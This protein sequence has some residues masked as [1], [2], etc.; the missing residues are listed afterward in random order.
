MKIDQD[1]MAVLANS[2]VRGANLKLPGQLDRKLYERV[3]KVLVAIGGKWDRKAQAHV[4][5]EDADAMVDGILLTGEYTDA[6]KEF[7][8]FYTPD[9]IAEMV[10]ERANIWRADDP[11]ERCRVLEPSAGAGALV[12]AAR[13][14]GA[15]VWACE[16]NPKDAD[17][18]DLLLYPHGSC[19]RGDFLA[20]SPDMDGQAGP[21]FDRVV[22]NPPFSKGQDARHV[23]HALK[24][25]KPGGRLVAIMSP[26]VV[27]RTNGAY[28]ELREYLDASGAGFSIEELP[29]GSFKESGTMVNTV[30]LTV[31]V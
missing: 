29:A 30:I 13:K 7:D 28:R 4:F 18:L 31:D 16:K 22:M 26:G 21:L 2:T 15:I 19:I 12:A 9:A 25:L 23:L 20:V 24:F 6:K 10:A 1:V 27:F 8:A 17:K 5:G 11:K 14:R 3:N